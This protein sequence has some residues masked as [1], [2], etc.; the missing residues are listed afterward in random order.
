NLLLHPGNL[1]K[2]NGDTP[3]V[4]LN[5]L[6]PIFV[7]FGVP[8]RYLSQISHQQS[9]GRLVVDASPEKESTHATGTLSVIDNTVDAN[10]GTIR[11]KA[12]FDNKDG[13]L[14]PGQFVNVVLTLDTQQATT[15]P[16]EAVQVGQSGA[17]VYVVKTDQTVEPRPVVVGQT[18]PGKVIVEKGV[19]AGETIVTDGQSRLF[20]GAKIAGSTPAAGSAK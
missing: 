20:P 3:L 13:R 8:E 6:K 17:F 16:T 10:T 9:L 7:S 2:A 11:L 4:V 12:V 19:A 1:V 15:I 18:V 5:Q 14:W